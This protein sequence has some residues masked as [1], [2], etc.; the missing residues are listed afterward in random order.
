MYSPAV[1]P[2][3]ERQRQ[4][5]HKL[6][7]SLLRKQCLKINKFTYVS[8]VLKKHIPLGKTHRPQMNSVSKPLLYDPIIQFHQVFKTIILYYLKVVFTLKI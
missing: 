2:A 7:H 3:G 6:N 4:E 1:I 5:D 8:Y